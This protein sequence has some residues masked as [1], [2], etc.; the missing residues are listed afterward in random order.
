MFDAR[1]RAFARSKQAPRQCV[2]NARDELAIRAVLAGIHWIEP[3]GGAQACQLGPD[4]CQT[5]CELP[6][7]PVRR[8]RWAARATL[9]G[10]RTLPGALTSTLCAIDLSRRQV[11]TA[12]VE[13]RLEIFKRCV[14]LS[15]IFQAKVL[16]D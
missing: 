4:R 5:E 10:R 9:G 2:K 12:A 13:Q 14:D 11:V 16:G 6:V 15:R 8:A 1:D 7:R 3:A